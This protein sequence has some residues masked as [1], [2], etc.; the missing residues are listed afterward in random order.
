MEGIL[1]VNN[2]VVDNEIT[3]NDL[4]V[5][6]STGKISLSNPSSW[7]STSEEE[8]TTV[9]WSGAF[10]SEF[11]DFWGHDMHKEYLDELFSACKGSLFSMM[12]TTFPVKGLRVSLKDQVRR[13]SRKSGVYD[14]SLD[15]MDVFDHNAI[16]CRRFAL[17]NVM[18]SYLTDK[19]Y[20]K[21][22]YA[23]MILVVALMDAKSMN[24]E[25]LSALKE[26]S[27]HK[28]TSWCSH[29]WPLLLWQNFELPKDEDAVVLS[30]FLIPPFP[31]Q[32]CMV[33]LWDSWRN[34][35]VF[36]ASAHRDNSCEIHCPNIS[37][38]QLPAPKCYYDFM[39]GATVEN[40]NRNVPY[41]RND[42]R[43]GFLGCVMETV[44]SFLA[45]WICHREENDIS[46]DWCP[47][48]PLEI[49]EFPSTLKHHDLKWECQ[50]AI[51]RESTSSRRRSANSA[52]GVRYSKK[53]ISLTPSSY[54]DIES[55]SAPLLNLDVSTDADDEDKR[56]SDGRAY[57]DSKYFGTFIAP[58]DIKV[59][60]QNDGR[61]ISLK[62]V[63]GK[64]VRRFS[65][66]NWIDSAMGYIKGQDDLMKNATEG[67]FPEDIVCHRER[68]PMKS[69]LNGIIN[70]P[71]LQVSVENPEI[72]ELPGDIHVWTGWPMFDSKIAHF[73]MNQW[74][75]AAGFLHGGPVVGEHVV[76][77]KMQ[78]W[79]DKL[80]DEVARAEVGLVKILKWSRS[81]GD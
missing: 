78:D 39:R 2:K 37:A 59:L 16:G 12:S 70:S 30:P 18:K 35:R 64:Y 44:R 50:N 76:E 23:V 55:Q 77:P 52:D 3:R 29:G 41:E 32:N 8:L 62:L 33:P 34:W 11:G 28:F 9:R 17:E 14:S 54:G 31:W 80:H 71:V 47:I 20:G 74:L 13:G 6:L 56:N 67:M 49:V 81:Y 27:T 57:P 51:I 4:A 5:S 15:P 53:P 25:A 69:D 61:T 79:E 46:P 7:L 10:L 24:R 26:Y 73:E 45:E 48:L 68:T 58:D 22:R 19:G 60:A 43:F 75:V 65:W 42:A 40:G 72:P 38:S 1:K 66:K 36:Q 21:R 63:P